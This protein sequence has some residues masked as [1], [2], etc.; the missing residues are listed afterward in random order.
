MGKGKRCIVESL[1]KIATKVSSKLVTNTIVSFYQSLT[2]Q[3]MAELRC[4]RVGGQ[5]KNKDKTV[6]VFGCLAVHVDAR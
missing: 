6:A 5:K 4:S 2:C 3:N 1:M